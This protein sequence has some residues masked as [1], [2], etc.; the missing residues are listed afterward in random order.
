MSLKN[1]QLGQGI[2][3][4]QSV[5]VGS[6]KDPDVIILLVNA[7]TIFVIDVEDHI[8]NVIVKMLF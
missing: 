4:V 7:E 2:N 1:L 3:S 5:N 6:K 8:L